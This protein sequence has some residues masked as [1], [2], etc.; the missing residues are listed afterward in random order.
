MNQPGQEFTVETDIL[1]FANRKHL[2]NCPSA[3][4][5]QASQRLGC[6]YP[7]AHVQYL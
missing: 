5:R 1:E 6:L 7:I 2:A 3:R 4:D